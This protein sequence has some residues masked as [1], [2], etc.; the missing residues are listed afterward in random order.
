MP[1]DADDVTDVLN[2][3]SL[4]ETRGFVEPAA[5]AMGDGARYQFERLGFFW[6]DPVDSRPSALVFNRIVA[7]RD[8]WGKK[9]TRSPPTRPSRRPTPRARRRAR[10]TRRAGLTDA[11]RPAY[12]ALVARGVGGEEAA[13]LAPDD[14]L[15]EP[16][17]GRRRGRGAVRDAAILLVQDV[18]PLGGGRPRVARGARRR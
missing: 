13:V 12:D 7:L 9:E 1:E 3:D 6:P 5:V 4:V 17:R 8:S 10:R 16:V 2:P 15:G 11:Q 14:A 18:R